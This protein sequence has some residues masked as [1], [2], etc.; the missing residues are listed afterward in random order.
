MVVLC[1]AS[2][3]LEDLDE[4]TWLVIGIGG[5]DLTF[6]G[7]DGSVPRDEHSH[8]ASSSLNSQRERSHI[9]KEQ[10]LH[11]GISFS[12]EDGSLDSC[13]VGHSLIRVDASVESFP[14]EEVSQHLLDLGDP[15][16]ASH[17]HHFM[18]LALGQARVLEDV[19]HG[20]HALPEEVHVEFLE[21]GPRDVGVVVF[22]LSQGLALDG[23][24]MG[25]RE[26]SLGLLALGPES[27]G[28]PLVLGD[29]NASLLLELSNAELHQ[30]VI[31]VLSS[32]MGVTVG[33]FH[34]KDS[35]LDGE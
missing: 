5:E 9:Q 6:L 21:L 23:S 15:S 29:V 28:G 33:S 8:H 22:S 24:L 3:S 17:Q 13:T 1:H 32:Q 2:F 34:L 31:K 12:S 27:P 25:G 30:P 18:D 20:G 11:V 35:L 26:D 14:I 10:V 4:D 16:G 19:L 7:R